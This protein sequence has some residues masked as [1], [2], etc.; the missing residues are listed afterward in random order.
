MEVALKEVGEGAL[1]VPIRTVKGNEV[2]EGVLC[3]KERVGAKLLDWHLGL[4]GLIRVV[5]CRK[6]LGVVGVAE[7]LRN[8]SEVVLERGIGFYAVDELPYNH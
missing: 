6:R 7:K 8:G 5:G 4:T 2:V 1:L 3:R